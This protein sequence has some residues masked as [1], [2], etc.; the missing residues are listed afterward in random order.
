LTGLPELAFLRAAAGA[1]LLREAA[2]TPG[3]LPQR[4]ARLR[5][6][7]SQE[8]VSAALEQLSLRQRA[9]PKFP[10]ASEMFFT[11]AG[12]EQASAEVVAAWRAAR[13]PE[14][15]TVLDL[16]CGNGGDGLASAERGPVM[17]FDI[18]PATAWCAQTNARAIPHPDRM[19]VA[20]ADV[21]RLRLHGD[22]A[23]FDPSRRREGRRTRGGEG[24]LPPLDFTDEIRAAIPN[25]CVK[26]S[27]AIDDAELEALGARVEFVSLRGEC[28]EAALWFGD[29]GP[30]SARSAAVLPVGATLQAD[31]SAPPPAVSEPREWLYEPDPAVIRAHLIAEIA[32]RLGASQLDPQIAYLTSDSPAESPF[33]TAYRILEWMPFSL[34]RLDRRLR[35]MGRRVYAV[36]RR[37]VPL[38]PEEIARTLRGAG[39][40]DAVVVLTRVNDKPAAIL[41]ERADRQPAQTTESQKE[42]RS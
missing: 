1:E 36:K 13:F 9:A 15:A 27:P 11:P 22:A 2:D 21:T 37:G 5:K 32:E 24:Y 16:C 4:V 39:D 30:R 35:E 29:I 10:R 23:F 14:G 31:L 38:E 8:L 17:A 12:V 33:A 19:Q 7:Y 34:K 18:D 41:C 20:T 25:V 40:R 6:R 3:S 26:V 42:H 28:K